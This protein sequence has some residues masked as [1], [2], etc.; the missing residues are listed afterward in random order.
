MRRREGFVTQNRTYPS[1]KSLNAQQT[2]GTGTNHRAAD[3][4]G[5]LKNRAPNP[6]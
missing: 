1:P 2:T 6:R 5:V 3:T 4:L